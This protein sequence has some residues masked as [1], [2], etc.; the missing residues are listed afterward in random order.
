M[1]LSSLALVVLTGALFL[2][3]PAETFAQQRG[4]LRGTLITVEEGEPLAGVTVEL[5]ELRRFRQTDRAG[6]YAFDGVEPGEYTL[7]FSL[8]GRATHERRVPVGEATVIDVALERDAIALNPL[9]VLMDRTRLGAGGTASSVPGSVHVIGAEE[10]ASQ[11]LL[12]D[13]VHGMLRRVP[14]VNVQEED[15]FGL[16]PNIGMRGT[17]TERSSKIT[18]MEDGVLIAPAPYAAPAAYYFPVAGRMEAVEVRKGSSQ[19]KYGPRTVGGALNL[20]STSI[21]DRFRVAGELGGGEN[22]TGKVRVSAGD[23]YRNFGWMAET[24]Q[25]RT[26]GFKRLDVGGDTGF[27]IQ[28]YVAKLRANSDRAAPGFYHEL[29]LKLGHHEE[30]SDETYLG[31]TDADFEATPLRRYAASQQDVMNTD[32]QQYQLRYFAQPARSVDITATLYRNEF[33]RNWF[34]LQSVEGSGIGAVVADPEEFAPEMA[35]LRGATSE[36]GALLVRANNREYFSQG[37]QSTLGVRFETGPASHALE[38]G[39]RYHQDEEDRFQHEDAFRMESGR[40]VLTRPGAPGSQANRVAAADALAFFV[41]DHFELGRLTLVP[42]IR[43][44]S[45]DF[46][47][48][49]Y[50]G[51]DPDRTAPTEVRENGVEAWIPGVGASFLLAP[52]VRLLG[53]V[54]E[55]FGP[56]GPGADERTEPESSLNYELGARVQRGGLTG[57]AVGFSSD[58]DNIL[59]ASTLATGDEGSGRLFNGG[60]VDVRGLEVSVEYDAPLDLPSLGDIRLPL[61]LAYTFTD[62][63]FRT[64]FESDFEPWGT[65]E[66][67][68]ELPYL[69][70]HQLHLSAGIE[71]SRWGVHLSGTHGSAMRTRAGQ[72]P[73]LPAEGTDAFW[74]LGLMADYQ[75]TPYASLFAGVENL[76]NEHYIVARR[77][78]GARPGLPR[79]L[80]AGVRIDAS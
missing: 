80:Q 2:T 12:Y 75:V 70:K 17:G 66:P 73:I 19:V 27:E 46:T 5:V 59:G 7:R 38:F 47:R 62:A 24:Y 18:L 30:T 39:L 58:Y 71:S 29:E 33:A 54:H 50:S 49:D 61:Q 55:G 45:I 60:A 26:D 78:A 14:G 76:T 35:I 6:R 31:L 48:T 43:F 13:D 51:D 25:I 79:T 3:A 10:L 64:A 41:Q 77:P 56:P 37:I 16:R 42:G 22:G 21:P 53:G 1:R 9:M 36:D 32:H 11:P 40:M 69:A 20:V 67:G 8:L 23:A 28:D 74:V 44:E 4:S 63:T 57:Q 15:G 68:D 65:V 52:G 34:K 72:G